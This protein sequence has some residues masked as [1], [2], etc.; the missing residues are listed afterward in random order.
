MLDV[1]FNTIVYGS[2]VHLIFF[3]CVVQRGVDLPH[4]WL[5]VKTL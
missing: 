2:V 4:L 1:T 5:E 3:K